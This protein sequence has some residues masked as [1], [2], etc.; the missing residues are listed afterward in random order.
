MKKALFL[1]GSIGILANTP[2]LA[3]DLSIGDPKIQSGELKLTGAIRTRYIHKDYIVEAN[4]GSKN[5]DWRLADIKAVL[6]YENP[7]WIASMGVRCY[8]YD[9]LCLPFARTCCIVRRTQA[10]A[11]RTY[12]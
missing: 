7:N 6:S 8:Q 3:A 11:W 12:C 10:K 2:I 1:L 4:E 9:R 5:D